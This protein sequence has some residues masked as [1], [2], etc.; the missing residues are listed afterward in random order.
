MNEKAFMRY[1]IVCVLVFTVFASSRAGIKNVGLPF[2]TN[3][4][5]EVYNAG[6]QNWSITEDERGF[7][8][9]ANNDGLLEYD[10][11]SWTIYPISNNSIIRSVC[12]GEDGRIYAGAF[13]EF[14][15]FSPGADGK[16]DYYS[17]SDEL[18][19]K[20]KDLGEIWQ[21]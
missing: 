16:L 13:D 14:G 10:G 2:I 11:T 8:Y 6:T 18:S 15:Y 17:L 9:F 5:R 12:K 3:Y 4:K 1:L 20:H 7:I 21:V 19:E